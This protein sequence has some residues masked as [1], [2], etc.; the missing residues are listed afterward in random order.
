MASPRLGCRDGLSLAG[1]MSDRRAGS[2]TRAARV[3]KVAHDGQAAYARCR[4]FSDMG[5]K[6]DLTVPLEL[7]ASVA[8]ALTRDIVLCGT[9]VWVAGQQ[10]GIA[11][12]APV[13]SEA[14]LDAAGPPPPTLIQPDT[15][16]QLGG[17]AAASAAPLGKGFEPG[18]K[19]TVVLGP[20][21]EQRGVVRW[22]HGNIAALE[23]ASGE[24]RPLM[25]P[26]PE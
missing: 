24:E 22:A 13:N 20:H 17:R 14:L 9:V 21:D 8:V 19:V 1:R 15:L 5:V 12:D 11:F 25:L 16:A 2:R 3:V 18:L 6:L 7:N 26:A 10:C 4:D 23:L